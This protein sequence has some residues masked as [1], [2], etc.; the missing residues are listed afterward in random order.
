LLGDRE[1]VRAR[2][3]K[4]GLCFSEPA[5]VLLGGTRSPSTRGV[6]V[7]GCAAHADS[8]VNSSA[9]IARA[10][11]LLITVRAHRALFTITIDAGTC[12]G[13]LTTSPARERFGR[14]LHS[15]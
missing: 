7:R 9:L 4:R 15:V 14:G 2:H 12:H 8:I 1:R 3:A 6:I 13:D 10:D 11:A 5:L